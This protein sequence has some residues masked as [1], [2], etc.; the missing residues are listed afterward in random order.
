[1]ALSEAEELELL[2]LEAEE[3]GFSMPAQQPQQTEPKYS[4]YPK[5]VLDQGMMGATS[6]FYKDMVAPLGVTAA[7]IM[8][9]PQALY[10]GELQNPALA[11]QAA[12]AYK[13]TNAEIA[14]QQKDLYATSLLSNMGGGLISAGG[15]ASAFPKATAAV[16][17]FTSRGLLPAIG[18]SLGIGAASGGLY[19]VGSSE[20]TPQ[21]RLQAAGTGAVYG[22]LGGVAG[23][24]VAKGLGAVANPL[25]QR[26]MKLFEKR[27]AIKVPP[28]VTGDASRTL[29]NLVQTTQDAQQLTYGQAV[30]SKALNQVTSA[31]KADY[32]DNYEQILSVWQ[33]S[34]QPLAQIAGAALTRKAMGA[35]QYEKALP[36]TVKYFTEAITEAKD[37]LIQ[38]V[39]KNIGDSKSY[40][41]TAEDILAKGR[42]K[43]S[44]FYDKAYTKEIDPSFTFKPEIK[45][46][47]ES[48]KKRYPSELE[49]LSD[50]S[51]KVLDYAKKELDDQ[52]GVAK[53]SGENN[54]VRNRTELKDE[55]LNAMD[56]ASPDY[57]QGR[58]IAGDYLSI[59]DAMENGQKFVSLDPENITSIL[60]NSSDSEKQAFKLGFSKAIASRIDNVN[61][62]ANP[63][64]R[65]FGS[66]NKQAQLRAALTPDEYKKLEI[67]M[68]ATNRLFDMKNKVLGNSTTTSKAMA[69]AEISDADLMQMI[70]QPK[71]SAMNWLKNNLT[72]GNKTASSI[73][74]LLYETDPTKKLLILERINGS[75]EL[76]KVEKQI[77]K[78][79]YFNIENRTK[80]IGANLGGQAAAMPSATIRARDYKEQ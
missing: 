22:S 27:N 77:V 19:G 24:G 42:K 70:T 29:N 8:S 67:D 71:K 74:D 4:N 44:P 25:T 52:I 68:K 47:I 1:M 37:K 76:S 6:G 78:E 63:Y 66:P 73:A 55:L 5:A 65:V 54:F 12:N 50:S 46:A 62:G 64:N 61:E 48:A 49:G 26:V 72:S 59:T 7:A 14:A 3:A 57:A 35:A 28:I 53:R 9:D 58:A 10:S 23:V 2:E 30:N 21:E 41:A 40:F 51:I 20:G 16:S 75:K 34:D 43:A 69:A 80:I 38:S 33:E 13:T 56:S 39:N 36:K 60:K 45:A 18:T 15:V 32:P 17:Q 79:Q 11:E 31:L